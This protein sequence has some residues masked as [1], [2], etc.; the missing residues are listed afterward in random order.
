M[1]DQ[2]CEWLLGISGWLAFVV[3]FLI[4]LAFDLCLSLISLRR[5]RRLEAI[6]RQQLLAF[7]TGNRAAS[8]A[9]T[10]QPR[11][12]DFTDDIGASNGHAARPE[13]MQ[14]A[15]SGLPPANR[16]QFD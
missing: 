14:P 11:R 16:R 6:R 3:L 10:R 15:S 7:R 12:R 5:A 9:D 1:C 4:L 13:P 8:E 2:N